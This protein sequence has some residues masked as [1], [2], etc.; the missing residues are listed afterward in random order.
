MTLESKY[1]IRLDLFPIPSTSEL[2]RDLDLIS[3]IQAMLQMLEVLLYLLLTTNPGE[4]YKE[5][6][7]KSSPF[8][9]YRKII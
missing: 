6:G 4:D 3:T 5:G 1:Q 7:E 9:I 2:L 8:F